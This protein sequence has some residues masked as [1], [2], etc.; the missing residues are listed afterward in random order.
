MASLANLLFLYVPIVVLCVFSFNNSK[1]SAQ[2]QG[3]SLRWYEQLM[4]DVALLDALH[5]SLIVGLL[6]TLLATIIGIMMA[7]GLEHPGARSLRHFDGAFVLSLVIPEIM[8]G[9]SLLLF[10]VTLTIPLGLMT[11]IIGHVVMNIPVVVLILRARLRKL[12]RKL[13]E[14]AYDLGASPFQVF[15]FV[16]FPLLTPAIIGAM[17]MAFTISLDDFIVAFFTAGPGSTTLPLR[18]YSMVKSGVTPEINAL[19][20]LL[21]VISMAGIGLSLYFQ[22]VGPRMSRLYE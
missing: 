3:F 9:V 21:V 22:R 19:S 5:N 7:V 20:T 13:T 14:A 1:L 8:L 6:S 15:R 12:D 17:L 11:I 18:V 2:W 10:F 4:A 16:T